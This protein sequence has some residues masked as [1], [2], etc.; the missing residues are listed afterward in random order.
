[1]QLIRVQSRVQ[2]TTRLVAVQGEM[3]MSSVGKVK[4]AIDAAVAERPETIVLDLSAVDFC[5]SSAIQLVVASHRRATERGMRFVAIRPNGRAWRA[6]EICNIDR[7][8]PFVDEQVDEP[9]RFGP[10]QLGA[11]V[12]G[13]A[14]AAA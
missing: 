10:R 13:P 14:P 8:V 7:Q 3:D 11:P 4:H 2:G 6:F 9:E 5:D 1:M 12:S